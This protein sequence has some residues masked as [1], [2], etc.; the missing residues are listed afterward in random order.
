MIVCHVF[1]CWSIYSTLFLCWLLSSMVYTHLAVAG[2]WTAPSFLQEPWLRYVGFYFHFCSFKK[3]NLL[4]QQN[5][6]QTF[7][8][9]FCLHSVQTQWCHIG[10]SL[11]SRTPFTY[12]VPSDKWWPVISLNVLLAAVPTLLALRCHSNPAFFLTP[13]PTGQTNGEKKNK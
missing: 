12:R 8:H 4:L 6:I 3:K 2:C 9:C 1:R 11:H 10:G 7:Q 13:V 5:L